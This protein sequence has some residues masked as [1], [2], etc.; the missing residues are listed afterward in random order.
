ML[1]LSEQKKV[2][3]ESYHTFIAYGTKPL[4]WKEE[5]PTW[6]LLIEQLKGIA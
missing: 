3:P 6:D 4:D 2:L 5:P 1:R